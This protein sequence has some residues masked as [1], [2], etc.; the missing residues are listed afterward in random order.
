MN[1]LIAILIAVLLT[2]AMLYLGA[3]A[4]R[5]AE[6]RVLREMAAFACPSCLHELGV[7]AVSEGRD[8]SP[9]EELWDVKGALLHCRPICR[10]IRCQQCGKS[11][12]LRLNRQGERFGPRLSVS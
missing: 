2:A 5:I 8:C 1:P 9:F 3:L 11:I 7:K 10:S 4:R 6:K 12:E